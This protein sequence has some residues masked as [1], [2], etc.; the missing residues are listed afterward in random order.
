MPQV[1]E[2]KPQYIEIGG[3]LVPVARPGDQLYVNFRAFQENCL[4]CVVR[5]HDVDRDPV[6][7]VAF[8]REA[9]IGRGESSQQPIC[10]LNVVLPAH[11]QVHVL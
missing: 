2:G 6:G 10:S 5:I 11:G 1:L 4:H 9:K 3:N 8:R 7:T